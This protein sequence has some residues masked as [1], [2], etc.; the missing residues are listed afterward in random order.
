[1]SQFF[2]RL[3][4]GK[5]CY[6]KLSDYRHRKSDSFRTKPWFQLYDAYRSMQARCSAVPH[7]S[8]LT[9]GT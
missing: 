2:C 6:V 7:C 1:M 3:F 4:G 9:C 5:W 8:G